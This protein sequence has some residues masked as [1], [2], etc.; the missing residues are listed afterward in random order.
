MGNEQEI[1]TLVTKFVADLSELQKGVDEYGK[2][3]DKAKKETEGLNSE[4]IN[5]AASIANFESI[6]GYARRALTMYTDAFT[7]A[8]GAVDAFNRMTGT[9]VEQGGKWNNIMEKNNLQLSDLTYGF[10]MLSN[11]MQQASSETSSAHKAFETLGVKVYDANGHLRDSNT[12][13]LETMSALA[14]VQNAA[15][16]TALAQDTIGRGQMAINKLWADGK[17]MVA[18]Y[19][20]ETTKMTANGMYSY[21]QYSKAMGEMNSAVSDLTVGLGEGL[22]PM[23]TRFVDFLTDH[24]IPAIDNIGNALSFFGYRV[25]A[26]V[27]YVKGEIDLDTFNKM[28]DY[29]YYQQAKFLEKANAAA[30]ERQKVIE[31]ANQPSAPSTAGFNETPWDTSGTGT[32]SGGSGGAG[33]GSAEDAWLLSQGEAGIRSYYK[34]KPDLEIKYVQA[35]RKLVEARVTAD[36]EELNSLQEIMRQHKRDKKDTAQDIIDIERKAADTTLDIARTNNEELRKEWIKLRQAIHDHPIEANIKINTDYTTTGGT[37]KRDDS[38]T[39][40]WESWVQAGVGG[41]ES[42]MW[43]FMKSLYNTGR[44]TYQQAL[45]YWGTGETPPGVTIGSGGI[46]KKAMGGPVS[47]NIPYLVGE[48]GPEIFAPDQNGT[49]LPNGL[50]GGSCNIYVELDGDTIARKIAAPL[51]GEIRVRTGV[52]F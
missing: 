46:K 44:Y 19:D 15:E 49:I 39:G 52:R 40:S 11:N 31:K 23:M 51:V 37:A 12:V 36:L 14:K 42:E 13:M 20:A 8:Y 33:G 6:T 21:K 4:S 28:T 29:G 27:S 38:L 5:L 47:A 18:I 32:G 45:Q 30:L 9:T 7:G 1:G 3:M 34:M 50:A 22:I 48:A 43:I 24:V 17:D 16:R 35:Y 10:R 26:A 25:A 2:E 41:Y